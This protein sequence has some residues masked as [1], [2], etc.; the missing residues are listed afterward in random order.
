VLPVT[1]QIE[2][3]DL[4]IAWGHL[5][6]SLNRPAIEPLGE[7]LP[8]TEIFRRLAAELDLTDPGL[9]DSDEELVRQLLDSDHPWLDGITF[10]RLA[11]QTWARLAVPDGHRPNVDAPP[12]TGD[13]RLRLGPLRYRP[14]DETPEGDPDLA[15][16]YPLAL[17]SRK[18]HVR[19]LNANYGGFDEHL[20]AEGE[21]LLQIHPDDA[22]G[23]GVDEGDR[24]VVHNDR[25]VLTLRATLT[26]MVPPGVVAVPFG[27]WNRHTAEGRGVNALTN[28]TPPTR[29]RGSAAFHD[30]L[31]E[32][33]LAP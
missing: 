4:G 11:A 18:Q 23:R 6:L 10:E 20:P 9:R 30:T 17:L 22:A 25:G 2:H 24:V 26:D 7:A 3:L 32:V 8:N 12:A 13:G 33:E 19:F 1:T 5:Y 14:G 29:G 31:V 27:W 28:P 16:R 21:P 15:A